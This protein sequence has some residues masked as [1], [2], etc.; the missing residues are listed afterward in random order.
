MTDRLRREGV[1]LKNKT[2]VR[3]CCCNN[4]QDLGTGFRF[5]DVYVE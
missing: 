3:S 1:Q 5:A 2:A 4:L